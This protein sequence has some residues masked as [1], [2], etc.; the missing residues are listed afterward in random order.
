MKF[1]SSPISHAPLTDSIPVSVKL[2]TFDVTAVGLWH[3]APLISEKYPYAFRI[4]LSVNVFQPGK[5]EKIS[6]I[7]VDG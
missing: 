6:D 3:L 7:G 1:S 4:V 2:D 5:E